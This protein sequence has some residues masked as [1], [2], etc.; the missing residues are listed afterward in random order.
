MAA[1]MFGMKEQA[2]TIRYINQ[3]IGEFPT[4]E[5]VD[6]AK[7]LLARTQPGPATSI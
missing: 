4:S 1:S 3:L 5:L 6:R 7:L 2:E